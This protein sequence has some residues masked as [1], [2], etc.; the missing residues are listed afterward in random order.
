MSQNY[1][2]IRNQQFGYYEIV[3]KPTDAMLKDYYQQK[4]YQ[5]ESA[6]Y[7]H[8]YN[9]AELNYFK[10]KIAQKEFMISNLLSADRDK[11]KQLT[12][13]D[14]GCGEGFTLDYFQKNG[15]DVTGADYSDFGIIKMNPHLLTNF[16]CGNI[17]NT[18]DEM[19]QANKKFDV[20][21][22]DN[23]L[24]HVVD[25]HNLLDKLHQ[26]VDQNG[27]LVIEVPNDY[28]TFQLALLEH[29]QV[30]KKY[31]EAYPDHLTYFDRNSLISTCESCNWATGKVISDFPIEWFLANPH[32][33]YVQDRSKG[34]L[35]HEARIFIENFI[36]AHAE[37]K[38]LVID[39]FEA[40]SKIGQGRQLIGFFVKA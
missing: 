14:I 8:E 5:N 33:N 11:Q 25:P 13:L 4:Y 36:D 37:S 7:R 17:W 1:S 3:P 32:S 12:L 20:L 40:M 23:V 38:S 6:N 10:N 39:F 15:W 2:F 27:V 28:T 22:L 30:E 19:I 31:W 16:I 29:K 34:R 9:T 35:A 18:L 21:W 24:E 26:L